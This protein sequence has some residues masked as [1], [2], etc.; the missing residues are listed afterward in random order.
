MIAFFE[1]E[2]MKRSIRAQA[3]DGEKTSLSDF[4]KTSHWTF[5][6]GKDKKTNRK[7]SGKKDKS[8]FELMTIPIRSKRF[9]RRENIVIW[10]FDY[11]LLPCLN[12]LWIWI[13]ICKSEFESM[14]R[15]IRSGGSRGRENLLSYFSIWLVNA[16]QSKIS[17]MLCDQVI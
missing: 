5:F 7:K 8:K 11:F 3:L 15:Q 12:I 2:F 9:R 14:K 4:F 6:F 13:H 1:F 17:R 10:L 16:H